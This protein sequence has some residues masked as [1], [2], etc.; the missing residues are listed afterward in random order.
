MPSKSNVRAFA[1]DLPI[2]LDAR[3]G[4]VEMDFRN[5]PF[6]PKRAF[7]VEGAE[8]GSI[9]G[10]HAHK[11]CQQILVCVSG[12]VTVETLCGDQRATHV[13]D[14]PAR[15]LLIPARIWARQIYGDCPS[16]LLVLAS[17]HYDPD[18]YVADT[19]AERS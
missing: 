16:R 10:G 13:L 9:R 7:I 5:L 1:L 12:V 18:S 8:A 6:V 3:G 14:S 2:H 15:A 4:L 11:R 19:R 17:H